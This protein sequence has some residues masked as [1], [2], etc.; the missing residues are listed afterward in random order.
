[1]PRGLETRTR[2][3]GLFPKM[4]DQRAL[5]LVMQLSPRLSEFSFL[6]FYSH[7]TS[8]SPCVLSTARALLSDPQL[9]VCRPISAGSVPG[10]IDGLKLT[11][12]GDSV[13]GVAFSG[14]TAPN[15]TLYNSALAET[16]ISTGIIYTTLFVRHW[17][18]CKFAKI[19]SQGSC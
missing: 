12:L 9:I 11:D 7:F 18:T 4:M 6:Y 2:L 19:S 13:L 14:Q 10:A 3:F 8:A 5:Q 17:D 1:M 16:P 15:G